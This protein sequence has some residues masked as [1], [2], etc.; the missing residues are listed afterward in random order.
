MADILA[1]LV[2]ALETSSSPTTPSSTFSGLRSGK[3]V[4]LDALQMDSLSRFEVIMHMEEVLDIELDEDEILEQET[5][6]GLVSFIEQ[7][8]ATN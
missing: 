3:D 1:L 5:V 2:N 4:A 8:V 6:L 7:R